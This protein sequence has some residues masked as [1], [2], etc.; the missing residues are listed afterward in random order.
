MYGRACAYITYISD[1]ADIISLVIGAI[2]EFYC[3][4]EIVQSFKLDGPVAVRIFFFL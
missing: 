2:K 3:A 4:H 1:T